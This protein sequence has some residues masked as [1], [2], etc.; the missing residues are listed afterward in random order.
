MTPEKTIGRLTLYRRVLAILIADGVPAVPSHR[1]ASK[2]GATAAQVRRDLMGIGARGSSKHGYPCRNLLD[3]LNDFLNRPDTAKAALVG[4]GNIGRA[5]LAYFDTQRPHLEL[6]AAFDTDVAK[7]RCRIHGCPCYSMDDLERVLRAEKLRVA[8]VAVP[9]ESAQ[10]VAARL[11]LAG[12]RGI[13]NFAPAALS[14]PDSVFVEN[15]D[16][17]MSLEK[18]AFFASKGSIVEKQL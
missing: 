3:N 1:L 11:A 16:V 13:V 9:G 14:L 5:L 8:I 17:T 12:V 10:A 7:T 6:A 2:A 18:A 15:I 4:I